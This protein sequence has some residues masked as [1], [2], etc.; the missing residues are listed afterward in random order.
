MVSE[1][2]LYS[3]QFLSLVI[4]QD[5]FFQI[6]IYQ[7][8]SLL[9]LHFKQAYSGRIYIWYNSTSFIELEDYDVV[10]REHIEVIFS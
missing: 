6:E 8:I 9:A 1:N 7:I 2:Q 3:A 10:N 4:Q 5:L